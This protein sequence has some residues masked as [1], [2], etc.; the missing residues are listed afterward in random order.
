MSIYFPAS[1]DVPAR[2]LYS[3]RVL[4]DREENWHDDSDWYAIVLAD[5]GALQRVDYATTR[6]GGS[7]SCRVDATDEVKI[8][9]RAWLKTWAREQIQRIV[10]LDSKIVK[11]GRIVKVVRGRK[12]PLGTTGRIFYWREDTYSPRYRNGYKTGPD[13]I[14]IGIA[15][16]DRRDERGR[17]ADV[18]W[19]YAANCEIVDP[20]AYTLS[21]AEISARAEQATRTCSYA[22]PF[23]RHA[24][25]LFFVG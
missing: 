8:A 18:A 2:E 25:G 12:V 7:G 11:D 14:K 6:Y 21:D 24:A 20:S 4:E 16:T 22:L 9:A 5:D 19:T 10:D 13:S 15:T 23:T 1:Y 3:G 17:Y